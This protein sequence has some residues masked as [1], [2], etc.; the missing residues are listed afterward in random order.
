MKRAQPGWRRLEALLSRIDGEGMAALSVD[1]GRELVRLYRAANSDLA[2]LRRLTASPDVLAYLRSLVGRAY[3]VI[4]LSGGR[5]SVLGVWGGVGRAEVWAVGWAAA[6]FG[7][8][9]G[10]GALAVAL[11][12]EA[13]GYLLPNQHLWSDP[14]ARVNALQAQMAQGGPT[15][16]GQAGWV[17]EVFLHNIHVAG[18]MFVLGLTLGLGT[19]V[20][21]VDNGLALGS[22]AMHYHQGGE[23][24]FFYAWI[25]PHGIPE[26][27][28]MWLAGGA[29][30]LLAGAW[31]CPGEQARPAQLKQ[32]SGRAMA[33]MWGSVVLLAIASMIEGTLSQIHP[34]LLSITAKLAFAGAV[35][36]LVVL[37]VWIALRHRAS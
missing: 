34:P 20:M 36:L 23:A 32:R 2:R 16:A 24:A 14:G 8:G 30:L 19:V 28:G 18:L 6:L 33:L 1:E 10:L 12:P 3:G 13:G 9:V 26:I 35:G 4:A 7:M 25:M 29:G 11:D 27:L 15:V 21:L 37:M 17:V 31:W 22:L 5:R